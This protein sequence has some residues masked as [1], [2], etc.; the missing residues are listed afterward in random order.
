[1]NAIDEVNVSVARRSPEHGI[2][3]RV[4]GGG[5]RGQIARAEIRFDFNNASRKLLAPFAADNQLA[6]QLTRHGS[7][8]A[9][10]ESPAQQLGLARH[11]GRD[12]TCAKRSFNRRNGLSSQRYEA[13]A[14]T[15]VSANPTIDCATT[16][17]RR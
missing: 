8:V 1:M 12:C 15:M 11:T 2:A 6:Q 7:W 10:E 5:V 9:I 4:S 13:A 16:M 14:S 17:H 3:R